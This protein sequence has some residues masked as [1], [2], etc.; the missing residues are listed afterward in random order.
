ML[1]ERILVALRAFVLVDCYKKRMFPGVSQWSSII[2]KNMESQKKIV[3]RA[4]GKCAIIFVILSLTFSTGC[5][6]KSY[7][8]K[9]TFANRF[10]S[11]PKTS[12]PHEIDIAF[13]AQKKR[14]KKEKPRKSLRKSSASPKVFR[15]GKRMNM[16]ATAYC[17]CAKCCGKYANGITASGTRTHWGTVA[18]PPSFLFFTKLKISAFPGIIFIVEDRGGAIKGNRID[19]WFP[20]HAEALRFGKRE[21]EIEIL[22]R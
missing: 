17:N 18:A 12:P 6:K 9:R 7:Q 14:D 19:I 22:G 20:T 4:V 16:I 13:E 5:D 2:R 15:G 10:F 3:K 8:Y 1:S 11:I 21:V